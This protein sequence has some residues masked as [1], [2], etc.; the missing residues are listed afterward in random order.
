VL[1]T[2]QQQQVWVFGIL[3]V[4]RAESWEIGDPSIRIEDGNPSYAHQEQEQ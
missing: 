3:T 4:C 1:F 2:F